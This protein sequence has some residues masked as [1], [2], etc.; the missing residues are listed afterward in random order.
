MD[1]QA[2]RVYVGRRIAEARALSDLTQEGLAD[3]L[4]I[5]A[6]ALSMIETGRHSLTVDRLVAIAALTGRAVTW[7][8]PGERSPVCH[9][10]AALLPLLCHDRVGGSRRHHLRPG[11]QN[12]GASENDEQ[13]EDHDRSLQAPDKWKR[14][15]HRG[16]NAGMTKKKEV[17][18]GMFV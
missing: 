15:F 9:G 17:A 11:D 18:P 4:G 2:V 13:R 6:G 3:T 16:G 12:E 8:L 10:D 7:F 1:K 14:S 5:S